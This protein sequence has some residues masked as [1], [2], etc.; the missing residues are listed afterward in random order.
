MFEIVN[1]NIKREG[2][3]IKVIGVGGAGG[4]AVQTMIA[5]KLSGVDF[6]AA[7]TD[8]QALEKNKSEMKI[9]LGEKLTRGLGAGANPD[10]GRQAA[11]E[12][13]EIVAEALENVDMVFITAGMGGGTG[14]GAASVIADIARQQGVLTV[15]VVTRPF[16][17]EGRKRSLHAEL[18]ISALREKVDTL[19]VIP[20]DKLLT[21]SD[22]ETPILNTFRKVD[23]VLLQAVQGI[24]DLINVHGLINLDFADIRTVMFEK[25]VAIMGVGSAQGEDRVVNAVKQAISSPLLDDISVSGAKGVIINVT[26]D[27][28]LSLTEVNE[29]SSIVT[30]M[31]HPDAE[32]I[33]GA[34]I[35]ENGDKT[36]GVRVTVIATG[37]DGTEKQT[38]KSD[39]SLKN[40]VETKKP[41]PAEEKNKV[42][43]RD[44]LLEKAKSYRA[45]QNLPQMEMQEKPQFS[46][47]LASENSEKE[48]S[49]PFS[50]TKG[51]IS[52]SISFFKDDE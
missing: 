43:P 37:F 11:I 30:Q 45:G 51:L 52:K 16:S 3:R 18:G 19:I 28:E 46:M 2:A 22:R 38:S 42:L 47:D 32:I 27:K 21:V 4:N 36:Q 5:S 14:T 13:C 41:A 34:V 39:S 17:F 12:S 35:N 26:G 7:N 10:I 25:G 48:K 44:R 1:E 33:F 40:T 31:A 23:E 20:N 6:I 24:S 50:S 49:S 9:Q 15:G 8:M 29:A